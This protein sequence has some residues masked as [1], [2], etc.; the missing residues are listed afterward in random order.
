MGSMPMRRTLHR[1]LRTRFCCSTPHLMQPHPVAQL[2]FAFSAVEM[3][4]QQEGWTDEQ[5]RLLDA[6][7]RHAEVS[8]VA[9]AAE[10]SEVEGATRKT[11]RLSLRQGVFRR[12][13]RLELA[14]MKPIWDK[15]FAGRRTLVHG[16]APPP[17]AHYGDL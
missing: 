6:L 10:R 4:G 16:I 14:A 2:V 8:T 5:K 3:L 13:G 15:T 7:A 1:E 17:A 12:M 11:Q 9:S